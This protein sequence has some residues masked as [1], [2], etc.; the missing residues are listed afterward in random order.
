MAFTEKTAFAVD[1]TTYADKPNKTA[2]EMKAALD[3]HG[4]ELRTYL[5]DT[6]L[7]ELEAATDGSSGADSLGMTQLTNNGSATKTAQA[8]AEALDAAIGARAYTEHNYV[9]DGESVADSL[10]ALDMQVKDNADAIALKAAASDLSNLAGAGRTTET[11]KGNAD[12]L[13]DHLADYA[14]HYYADEGSTDAYAI[15]PDPA[16][17][18]Y[19]AGQVFNVLCPTANTGAAS[20]NVN[21]K[22][23]VSI[24]KN[25]SE[26][27]E[28]GDIP[29]G[30]VITV[31]YDG[32]NFQLI[33][34]NP[35]LPSLLTAAGDII[36]A[37]AAGTPARLAIGTALQ[38][39]R[40]NSGA[41]GLEW[42]TNPANTRIAT[43]SYTGDGTD[44]R[45]IS[46]GFTPKFVVVFDVTNTAVYFMNENRTFWIVGGSST[47]NSSTTYKTTTNGFIVGVTTIEPNKASRAFEW[48]AIG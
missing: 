13:S 5:N 29:A 1:F 32:T 46:V 17:T 41:T 14:H 9:T 12:N 36:Y 21:A 27:L 31:V 42:F 30:A 6:L 8:Q 24:K 7:A 39:L 26:D 40:V 33:P 28:T 34:V 22:G 2:A 15:A 37:S 20:L 47:F 11:V 3:S 48:A 44:P 10:D 43:G 16:I 4:D 25:V 45:T 18:D 19:A 35:I 23:A 38:Q